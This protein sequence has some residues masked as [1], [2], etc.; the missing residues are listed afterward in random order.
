MRLLRENYDD[1]DRHRR[2]EVSAEALAAS[3]AAIDALVAADRLLAQTALDDATAAKVLDPKRQKQVDKEL[4]RALKDMNPGDSEQ[5]GND[6]DYAIK[7]YKSAWQH[8]QKAIKEP[9]REP[10]KPRDRR[11]GRGRDDGD[12]GDEDNNDDD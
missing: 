3:E 2:D 7:K 8:A 1:D 4:S 12:S 6:S 9:D 5:A 10:R 11:R